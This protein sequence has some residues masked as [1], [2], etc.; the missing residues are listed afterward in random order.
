MLNV[1]RKGK[2]TSI[3]SKAPGYS[4]T[5]TDRDNNG[6]TDSIRISITKG[7]LL[8]DLKR[9]EDGN[10]LQS[11]QKYLDELNTMAKRIEAELKRK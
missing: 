9:D 11:S 2:S 5:H 6:V 7:I 8:E 10:Y 3:T 4:V 1:L